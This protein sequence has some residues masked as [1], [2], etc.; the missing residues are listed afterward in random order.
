MRE[1]NHP[2][3]ISSRHLKRPGNHPIRTITNML[4]RLPTLNSTRP[5]R[6]PWLLLSNLCRSPPFI[7]PVVPSSTRHRSPPLHPTRQSHKRL[8]HRTNKHRIKLRPLQKIPQPLG[9][10]SS[11]SVSGTS[12]S[13]PHASHWRS[14]PSPH[15]AQPTTPPQSSSISPLIAHSI[16][17]L[18]QSIDLR[19]FCFSPR[20]P[21]HTISI[22]QPPVRP[23]R[24]IPQINQKLLIRTHR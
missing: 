9:P 4:H 22:R 19:L 5:N 6:P 16:H 23:K 1:Q 13:G 12:A 7:N 14:T 2:P 21:L 18:L 20:K 11:R 3:R 17:S 8:P 15:D 24:H 10:L